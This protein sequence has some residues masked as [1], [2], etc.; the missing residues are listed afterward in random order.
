MR[1]GIYVRIICIINVLIT[2]FMER[3][4]RRGFIGEAPKD[5]EIGVKTKCFEQRTI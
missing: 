3:T 1:F 2:V 4:I 5:N